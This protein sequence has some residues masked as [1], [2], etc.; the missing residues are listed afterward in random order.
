MIGVAVLGSTGSIG[1]STLDVLGRHPERFQVVALT[2][3]RNAELLAEQCRCYRPAVAAMADP[4]AARRLQS[5]L[6]GMSGAPEVLAGIEG[7]EQV[8]AL[9]QAPYVMAAIVGAAGLRPSLAAARAGKRVLL[10]NKEA[11]V[12]AGALFMD[13]VAESGAELLPIDSEHNAIFQCLPTGFRAGLAQVGVAQILLT[14]SGGPFRDWSVEQIAAVT[15]EQACAHP[16]WSMGRKISVD[17]ATLMNKGLEVIE[18]CWLF[19]TGPERVTV[20]VHPQSTVHSLVQYKDGSVL[21]EMGNPDMRT[22]IA[23]ALAWPERF[24]SG[25]AP[26]DL[27]A[28]GRLDFQAPDPGRFPCLRLAFEA[29]RAGDSAPLVLNASNEV[30]V[31]AFLE[32]RVGFPGIARVV[33]ETLASSPAQAVV[34]Q[35]L[36]FLIDLDRR[37]RATAEQLIAT[38]SV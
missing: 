4:A 9:P 27:V 12:M 3:N 17:S 36:A 10:A 15:P 8:A 32:G 24:D 18:A 37:A 6:A 34:G 35:D 25:V 16:V 2:A 7:L 11:L 29:A 33:E 19:G 14:A 23:H 31:A 38:G 22:P 26:L 28:L 1:L 21:A 5:L 13:A 20:V 30:A